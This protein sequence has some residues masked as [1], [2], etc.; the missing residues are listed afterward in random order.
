MDAF[1]RTGIVARNNWF[2]TISVPMITISVTS[3]VMTS[4]PGTH[5]SGHRTP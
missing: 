5:D 2:V 3:V 4:K 1:Y